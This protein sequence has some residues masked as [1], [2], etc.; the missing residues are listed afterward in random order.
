MTPR[1]TFAGRVARAMALVAALAAAV[2]VGLSG[3]IAHRLLVDREDARLD[4]AAAI[5][6]REL[7]EAPD[8]PAAVAAVA[9]DENA[10]GA[11]LGMRL[12]LYQGP[13][14]LGGDPSLRLPPRGACSDV[15]LGATPWR[16][17]VVPLGHGRTVVAASDLTPVRA[18]RGPL[19]AAAA[20]ALLASALAALAVS[21][22]A[23]ARI[24]GPLA[25]LRDAVK[26]VP[27]DAPG[28]A[29]LPPVAGYEEI[30][31]LHHA[32]GDLLTRLDGAL[33]QS[34]RFA[35][36]AAHELR[37]PLATMRAELDLAAEAGD[38][39]DLR[40]A[41]ARVRSTAAAL[42][43]RTER[44]LVLATPLEA[45][46]WHREAVAVGDVA[47][48]AVAALDPARRAR[49]VV[50]VDDGAFVRGDA[51]LLRMVADNALDN[52]LK[53]S[54]EGE[55]T[56][57]VACGD[58]GVVLRVADPGPG[59]PEGERVRV[60]EPFYRMSSARAGA[61]P[62]HGVGLALVAHV[63]RAHGGTA[64]FEDVPAGAALRVT[65][66]PWRGG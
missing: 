60:F 54:R 52:A 2:A 26:A 18:L 29:V 48:E 64:A 35:A 20:V 39:D 62:G 8:D 9:A 36:D 38:L 33:A 46:R 50:T 28:A 14:W 43:D 25:R 63:A 13:R 4:G 23:S 17:C 10:E 7:S 44:L 55:V 3:L 6:A 19:V 40:G 58:D 41:L 32:V 49:V 1:R 16:R 5:L 37:T 34:R 21:R 59:V 57:T 45:G 56:V 24:V 47:R 66:P 12:A 65:L 15:Q 11:R 31:A 30:D 42:S 22:A 61:V 53:F 27:A 51:T